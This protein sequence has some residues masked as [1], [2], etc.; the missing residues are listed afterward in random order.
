MINSG[1]AY[2]ALRESSLQRLEAGRDPGTDERSRVVGK[3]QQSLEKLFRSIIGQGEPLLF[4]KQ[5]T[6]LEPF[7]KQCPGK[8]QK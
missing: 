3:P 8:G 2:H 4:S 7:R 5:G 6:K 1:C